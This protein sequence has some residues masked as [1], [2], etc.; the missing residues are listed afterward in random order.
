MKDL[1]DLILKES[2]EIARNMDLEIFDVSIKKIRKKVKLEIIIDKEDG[3][4]GIDDCE[5]FSRTIESYLDEKDLIDTS[6]DL[7]VSSPGLDRP[8]RS[9]KDFIR[10]KG[11]L[12]KVILKERV[13]NRTA[14]KGYIEDI[15]D[16]TIYIKEKDGGKIIEFP[17][18][19]VLKANLEIDL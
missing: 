13:Q 9:L 3:Y 16:K 11:K 1:K 2:Q 5:R 4:V 17:Y 18:D 6:Y 14:I 10:F 12:V 19:I 15:N 7:I 8:L